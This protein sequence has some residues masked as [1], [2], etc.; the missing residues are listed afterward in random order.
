M[1]NK[2][3]AFLKVLKI[4]DVRLNGEEKESNDDS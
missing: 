4:L 3:G 2:L 1:K